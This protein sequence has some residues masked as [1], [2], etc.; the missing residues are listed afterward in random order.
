MQHEAS[1]APGFEQGAPV[2][3]EPTR[4]AAL[5]RRFCLGGTALGLLG[6]TGWIAGVPSFTT[7]VPGEPVMVPNTAA[8]LSLAGIAGALRYRAG[9]GLLWRGV[10]LLAATLVLA[11]GAA[12]LAEYAFN[13][14]L[15]IDQLL[16]RTHAG[17]YAGRPSPLTA[18]AF[19]CLGGAILLLDFRPV[20]QARPSEWLAL[21]A[22]LVA[23]T[24]LIGQVFGNGPLYRLAARAV[25][26]VAVPTAVGLL[27]I[28]VGVLLE[29]P[30]TGLMRLATSSDAAGIL[31]RRLLPAVLLAPPLFGFVVT[32]LEIEG[33]LALAL[34]GVGTTAVS[35]AVLVVTT[36]PISRALKALELSRAR[37]RDLIEQAADGIFL[38]NLEGQYTDVNAAGCRMLGHSRDEIVGKAITDLIPEDERERLRKSK[39]QLLQGHVEVGEWR[40]R[41]KDGS[42]LPVEVSARI[43]SDGRWQ[44]IVRDI[45]ER[46]RAEE[47]LRQSEER[48]VLALK[49]ADLAAW[50]WNI[51]T[52]VVVFNARWAEMRGYRPD[53]V[54]PHVDSW[55]SD[56]HPDDWPRIEMA[57]TDYFEGRAQE[58]ETEHRVR[59]KRGEWIWILDR[60]KVF[61]RDDEGKPLR[62]VGTELDVTARKRADERL[63]FLAEAGAVFGASLEFEETL[64]SVARL[65]VR[66]LAELCIVDIVGED[67]EAGLR[68]VCRDPDKAWVCRVLSRSPHERTQPLLARAVLESRQP[69]LI[70]KV[71]AEDLGSWAQNE[72]QLQALRGFDPGSIIVVPLVARGKLLGTVTLSS[73]ASSGSYDRDDLRVAEELARRAALSI[74]NAR[75]YSAAQRATQARDELMGVVAHDLRNPLG[76][77]LMQAAMLRQRDSSEG[78]SQPAQVIERAATRMR[79]L[80]Q[81]LLDVARLEAGHLTIEP[82]SVPP[83]QVLRDSVDAQKTLAASASLDLRLEAL[84]DLPDV[85]ADRDRL[86]QVFE[87]LVSNAVK[88]SRP[89]GRITVGAASGDGHVLFR[90][91]DTG[92]GIAPEDLPHVFE[93]FWQGQR[94]R[95]HGAGLGL[96]IVQ[97]IVEAHG[98]R[99]WAESQSGRGST[100]FFTIP[101]VARAAHRARTPR[102]A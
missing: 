91:A 86:L 17:P 54:T 35:L 24:A 33:P 73:S 10:W 49:G 46:K 56:V 65:A 83:G 85:W 58:Y 70:E 64:G 31:F 93:R 79:R 55:R 72:E 98:G 44:G 99:V 8:A 96:P 45:S 51:K 23:F 19:A 38:A 80:I 3:L 15:H 68:V 1:G 53:E 6:L 95:R 18:L 59:T 22:G 9:G 7:I 62:M 97:G 43:L 36:M 29:R 67:V 71:T 25:I 12:T 13:T 63:R 11:T 77:I 28:S 4:L 66:G 94:A 60:G 47:Q 40:L 90:V 92:A 50:D 27:L 89:G 74:E 14:T 26:G 39:A 37:T 81:D 75:L 16:V 88:F 32:R 20:A 5:G 102:V 101:V 21:V 48:I 42:Y 61:A 57:L 76:V 41:R 69:L 30:A 2:R 82:T 34:L 78:R 100:F 87:N 84:P 52:G